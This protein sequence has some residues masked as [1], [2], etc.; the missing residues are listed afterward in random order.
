MNYAERDLKSVWHPY[1]QI[2]RNA[3][4]INIVKG[5]QTLLIDE[6]GNKF[7]DAISSWWVNTHGHAN[8]YIAQKVSEQ[9]F[10]LEHVIFAGFTHPN[11]IILAE[12]L[13][14]H[15][16]KNHDKV[17]YSDNGSTAVEVAIK[18]A[19]QYWN[20]QGIKKTK[21]IAFKNAYHGDTFG[22]MSVSGRSVFT[23]AFESLLF[24]VEF[25]ETPMKGKENET[26]EALE[27]ALKNEDVAAFIFEPLVQGA[28]GM[29]MYEPEILNK[30][31]SICK[32]K[33][34][35][36][37]ADEVMTGF[38][39]TGKFFATDFIEEKP[40]L[41]CLSKGLTGGTMAFGVTTSTNKIFEAFISD[42][43]TKTLYHGHSY[44]ANPVACAAALASMDLYE[45]PELLNNVNRI[46]K[47]HE[48]FKT[49]IQNSELLKNVRQT[50]TIL[51]FELNTGESTNYLNDIR[52]RIYNFFIEKKI[53]IRPLGNIFYLIPPYCI[54]NEELD[55]V[56]DSILE[57]LSFLEN[58]SS[59]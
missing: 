10:E 23:N 58:E 20:N 1:T 29:I 21:I 5:D 45:K 32:S 59:N 12:R 2:K 39:R 7:I 16:P 40:D 44:T 26:I 31:I 14:S 3:L 11:A 13:L 19:L 57:F 38:Y 17:F 51:V 4:P 53:I 24:D 36:T 43:K 42:D 9:L 52:D 30:L 18:I 46:I 27:L 28:A 50:G 33:N 47:K 41:F 56:Y 8:P 37:I 55:Y 49:K 48:S 22:S 54:T 25:I 35:L 15:L 34:V 6:N